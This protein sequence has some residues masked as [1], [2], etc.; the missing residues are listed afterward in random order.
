[1]AHHTYHHTTFVIRSKCRQVHPLEQIQHVH[2][3]Y[4]PVGGGVLPTEQGTAEGVPRRDPRLHSFQPSPAETRRRCQ[5]PHRNLEPGG[6]EARGHCRALAGPPIHAGHIGL[7]HPRTLGPGR[8]HHVWH[9]LVTA[10]C[11]R[12]DGPALSVP[13]S[14]R[15]DPSRVLGRLEERKGGRCSGVLRRSSPG[16]CHCLR[17][18]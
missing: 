10:A 1:M 8:Q 9:P 5:T 6:C 14:V 16:I 12:P 11:H 7:A 17:L 13:R 15:H 4:S 18:G 3:G 2:Q